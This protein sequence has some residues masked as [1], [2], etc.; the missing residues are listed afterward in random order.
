MRCS[1]SKS[2]MTSKMTPSSK[3]V[4][5]S[6]LF[7]Q[8][9]TIIFWKHQFDNEFHK[10]TVRWKKECLYPCVIH[11]IGERLN[12]WASISTLVT[13]G[14]ANGDGTISWSSPGQRPWKYQ[15]KRVI[16]TF[17]RICNY[18]ISSVTF[19]SFINLIARFCNLSSYMIEV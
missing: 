6:S 1:L 4:G 13:R 19:L 5:V 10:L 15:Y 11:I 2:P 17:L 12:C 8:V 14:R 3:K 18:E 7:K 16:E 9:Q